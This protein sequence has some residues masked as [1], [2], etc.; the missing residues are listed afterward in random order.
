MGHGAGQGPKALGQADRLG[1]GVVGGYGLCN[2]QG[3][4]VKARSCREEVGEDESATLLVACPQGAAARARALVH[5]ASLLVESGERRCGEGGGGGGGGGA[6]RGLSC[7][8][9]MS[10]G[11]ETGGRSGSCH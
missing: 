1:G 10:Q 2:N 8:R 3:R 9:G 5:V 7:W 11:A 4:T 6:P